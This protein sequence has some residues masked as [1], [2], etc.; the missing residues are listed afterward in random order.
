MWWLFLMGTVEAAQWSLGVGPS[1]ETHFEQELA[2][3]QQ[4]VGH[5]VDDFLPVQEDCARSPTLWNATFEC[6]DA[7]CAEVFR[8][9]VLGWTPSS[10]EW[11][12]ATFYGFMYYTTARVMGVP[13]RPVSL[14]GTMVPVVQ[15]VD[16]CKS[17]QK[18]MWET[19]VAVSRDV[20]TTM[21]EMAQTLRTMGGM[22]GRVWYPYLRSVDFFCTRDV[23]VNL[24]VMGFMM[25][26]VMLV[27]AYVTCCYK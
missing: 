15:Y 7:A 14:K 16:T 23:Q 11:K 6:S 17:R 13:I 3:L 9:E 25:T 8:A 2:C 19:S 10:M 22:M 26:V 5:S 21:E 24:F 20:S 18:V 1:F 12:A 4:H 27:L